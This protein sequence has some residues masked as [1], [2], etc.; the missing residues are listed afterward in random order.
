MYVLYNMQCIFDEYWCIYVEHRNCT[1][2]KVYIICNKNASNIETNIGGVI[3]NSIYYEG[4]ILK[5]V[6]EEGTA[7]VKGGGL[8]IGK[9]LQTP[10]RALTRGILRVY[11]GCKEY[12][13]G[14][15]QV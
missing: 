2:C 14:I 9:I 6:R 10:N 3:H 13:E 7:A 5:N 15:K 4:R 8:K 1:S 12:D 11:K